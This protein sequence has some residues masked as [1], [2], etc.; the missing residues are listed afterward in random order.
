MYGQGAT[1]ART[2]K[3]ATEAATNQACAVLSDI[4]NDKIETDFLWL[5]LQGEYERLRELASG[6]N[7][8]NLNAQMIADYT[9]V[10][11]PKKIQKEI[12]EHLN[13]IKVEVKKIKSDAE[14]A[15]SKAKDDFEAALFQ[16]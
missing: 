5:Y 7:Q 13:S 9:V 15:R 16:S 3:L 12:I 10:L 6:N 8:P 11:P 1:R 2:A 4:D 14:N